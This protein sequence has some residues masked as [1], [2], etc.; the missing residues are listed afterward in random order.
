MLSQHAQGYY[1]SGA[2]AEVTL[3]ET[4]HQYDRLKLKTRCE[5]DIE[6]FKG[7]ETT[8]LGQ[9]IP[10]PIC[11]AATA[12]HR[13]ARPDGELLTAKGANGTPFMLSSWASTPLEDAAKMC[14]DSLKFFQIYCS[15]K[16]EVNADLW[17]RVRESG[18]T[19]MFLTTDTQLLG[20]REI[21]VRNSFELPA[22][23][24][25]AN[26][27]S[28][29]QESSEV[30]AKGNDSGLSIFVKEHKKLDMSWEIIPHI[31]E[32]SKLK[33]FVK[34]V[35]CWEDAKLAIDNG[36]DGIMVSNHGAR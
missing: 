6:K 34:G 24:R 8:S 12:F 29:L 14:P 13:L 17:R 25:L 16:E 30:K 36:A 20:K 9:K 7:L 27:T 15:R 28:Y 19:A 2:N 3:R 31:K 10:T 11:V 23:L 21:D 35:M 26:W 4:N 32:V 22:H 33:V 5:V 18:Y 1:Y